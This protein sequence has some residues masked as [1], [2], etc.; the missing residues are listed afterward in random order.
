MY[1]FGN[2]FHAINKLTS[3]ADHDANIHVGTLLLTVKKHLIVH[4]I[5]PAANTQTGRKKK[6]R[7][8]VL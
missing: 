4:D 1:L 6:S 3:P 8:K 2:L 7:E 5:L